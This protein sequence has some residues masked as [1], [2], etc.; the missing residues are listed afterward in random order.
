L[1]APEAQGLIRTWSP[2]FFQ[3]EGRRFILRM[4]PGDYAEQC[5]MQVRPMPTAVVRLGL[6]L[7]EFDAKLVAR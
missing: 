4:S 3:T 1:T 5:P 2:Q 6:V 7:T